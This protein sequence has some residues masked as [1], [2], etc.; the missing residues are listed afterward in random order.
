VKRGRVTSAAAAAAC[1]P[2]LGLTVSGVTPARAIP[3]G[4]YSESTVVLGCQGQPLVRPG[5]L[6]LT[7]ADGNDYLSGLTW[8]SWGPGLAG[9]AGVQSENDCLPYCAA[10]HVRRYPVDAVLWDTAAAGPGRQ[11][12]TRI[13]LLYPGARPAYDGHRGP[14]TVTVTLDTS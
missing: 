2:A 7:C 8:T 4:H 1:I 12:Y 3:A 11:R 5:R 10:G 6:T 9:A 14:A 13:T